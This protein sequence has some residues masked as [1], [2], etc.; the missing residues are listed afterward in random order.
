MAISRSPSSRRSWSRPCAPILRARRAERELRAVARSKQRHLAEHRRRGDGAGSTGRLVYANDAALRLLGYD[1]PDARRQRR[2]RGPRRPASRCSTKRASR[3][4]RRS[5]PD[6]SCSTARPK[7][8]PPSAG[9]RAARATIAGPSCSR[10][11]CSTT[12]ARSR[13][14]STSCTTSPSGGAPS[15][16]CA[17]L[18]RSER[19]AHLVARLRRDGAA[20]GAPHGAV[21]R[22]LERPARHR[23]RPGALDRLSSRCARSTQQLCAMAAE[24]VPLSRRIAAAGDAVHRAQH[25]RRL[26]RRRAAR[27][28]VR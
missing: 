6:G 8:A 24:P 4:I 25:A 9:G 2:C 11:R 17:C 5:C 18:T 3:S 14:P 16:A 10:G 27:R 22:R 20:R 19:G 26:R 13:S 21:A 7:R 1:G 15:S 28:A 12:R 23:G